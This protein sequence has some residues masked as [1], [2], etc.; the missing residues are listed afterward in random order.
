MA[1]RGE[2]GSLL[3]YSTERVPVEDKTLSESKKN[4][5]A[6]ITVVNE[7]EVSGVIVGQEISDLDYVT[8]NTELEVDAD[9]DMYP[10]FNNCGNPSQRGRLNQNYYNA[11]QDE[12][13]RQSYENQRNFQYPRESYDRR[14]IPFNQHPNTNR[15][16]YENYQKN[17]QGDDRRCYDDYHEQDSFTRPPIHNRRYNEGE[18]FL[19]DHRQYENTNFNRGR[20][21]NQSQ[22]NVGLPQHERVQRSFS[23]EAA[24]NRRDF[25]KSDS[26]NSS[27]N[28]KGQET[29]R[30]EPNENRQND[31][32]KGD[33]SCQKESTDKNN[34]NNQNLSPRPVVNKN[35]VPCV[36]SPGSNIYQSDQYFSAADKLQDGEGKSN[37][38]TTPSKNLKRHMSDIMG[39]H[40][41][42]K[43]VQKEISCK[44]TR[45]CTSRC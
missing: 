14:D 25:Q 40:S 18:V 12:R 19:S 43:G 36:F 8:D 29:S 21:R 3:H 7:I 20:R 38:K 33:Q 44:E 13:Y 2:L 34:V 15:N 4:N 11:R 10:R 45:K 41:E 42:S 39:N 35:S 24:G 27:E 9:T 37:V 6:S 1:C 16:H 17:Y 30:N 23:S 32:G 28:S 22:G 31:D 26:Y 5:K